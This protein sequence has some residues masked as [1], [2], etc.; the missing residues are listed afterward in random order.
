[1]FAAAAKGLA[2]ISPALRD[3]TASL[4]PPVSALRTV[5]VEVAAVA[6]QARAEGL[7]APFEDEALPALIAAKMWEPVYRPYR[8]K[9]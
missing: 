7:C 8:R 9:A 4:L 1:M 5:A 2:E 3:S 6:R